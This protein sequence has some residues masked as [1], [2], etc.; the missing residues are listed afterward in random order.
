MSLIDGM[1]S[2]LSLSYVQFHVQ[3]KSGMEQ[4]SSGASIFDALYSD[5]ERL[6]AIFRFFD[7]DSNGSISRDEFRQ[8]LM[9]V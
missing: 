6:E 4:P 2:D 8:V 9:S 5:R 3:L 1:N 7:T